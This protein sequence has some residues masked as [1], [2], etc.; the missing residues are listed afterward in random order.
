M[1][2]G[3]TTKG[4]EELRQAIV[5]NA[6]ARIAL[7]KQ[8]DRTAMFLT[9]EGRRIARELLASLRRDQQQ[10]GSR[11]TRP[12]PRPRLAARART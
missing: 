7:K 3:H 2:R 1:E 11:R 6:A 10:G 8:Q 12:R 4:I 9:L 5:R